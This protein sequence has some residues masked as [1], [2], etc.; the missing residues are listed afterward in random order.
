MSPKR[1][2][3]F[4]TCFTW[5]TSCQDTVR[6]S[7]QTEENKD[8]ISTT[9]KKDSVLNSPRD[10]HAIWVYNYEKG[11]P[12][13]QRIVDNQALVPNELIDLINLTKRTNTVRLELGKISNDTI[14]V[15]IHKSKILTQQMGTTGAEEYLSIATYT[16]TELSTI[17]FVNFDFE[18]G[19]HAS[20]GTYSRGYY[21]KKRN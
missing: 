14:F 15:K 10:S 17:N 16:L 18:L 7:K 19:D 21:T 8:R 12:E 4:F 1:A 9:R 13:Q 6:P 3:I 11:L 5:V 2:F 20:P